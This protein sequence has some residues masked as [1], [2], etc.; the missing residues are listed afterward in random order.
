MLRVIVPCVLWRIGCP[1]YW[2]L[3]MKDEQN[4]STQRLTGA[5]KFLSQKLFKNNLFYFFISLI[6]H[7][8]IC[9]FRIYLH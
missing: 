4:L 3:R 9:L 8:Y 2:I 7:V 1:P 6:K 5:Y